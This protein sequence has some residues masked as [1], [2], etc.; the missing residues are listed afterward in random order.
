MI[1]VQLVRSNQQIE[2]KNEPEFGIWYSIS[3]NDGV[4]EIH[5]NC[6]YCSGIVAAYPKGVWRGVIDER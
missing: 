5:K 3:T 4:L 6:G 1:K 2:F